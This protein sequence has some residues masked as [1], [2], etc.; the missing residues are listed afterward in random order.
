[1]ANMKTTKITTTT[2]GRIFGL[3]FICMLTISCS[4]GVSSNRTEREVTNRNGFVT[5][6]GND[7]GREYECS[8]FDSNFDSENTNIYDCNNGELVINR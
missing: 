4:G 8:G 3:F 7:N 2:I 6:K 5:L 1:M